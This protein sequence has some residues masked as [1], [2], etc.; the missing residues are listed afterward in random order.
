MTKNE[1]FKFLDKSLEGLS[2]ERK[3]KEIDRIIHRGYLSEYKKKITEG[4]F[5]KVKKNN[6]NNNINQEEKKKLLIERAINDNKLRN[7][8]LSQTMSSGF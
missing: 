5:R 2:V 8:K 1:L 3:E 4:S 7:E 6:F